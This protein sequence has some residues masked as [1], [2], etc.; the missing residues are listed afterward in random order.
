[1]WLSLIVFTGSALASPRAPSLEE[2]DAAING[3]NEGAHFPLP[4]VQEGDLQRLLSGE[5]VRILERSSTP[6]R[7]S[8]AVGLLLSDVPRDQVWV[9]CQD[10]HFAQNEQVSEAILAS[11]QPHRNTWFGLLDLPSPFA[12]RAW[13]VDVVNNYKLAQDSEN[14]A[15]EHYWELNPEGKTMATEA[16]ASGRIPDVDDK[17]LDQA[18]FTP[19]NH[20]AWLLVELPGGYS[21]FGYHSSTELAGNLP[22]NLVIQ[23]V[24]AQLGSM[25][26]EIV[27]RGRNQAPAHYDSDHQEDVHG[28]NGETIQRFQ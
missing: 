27:E 16:V 20:G 21:L 9:S 10:P 28:G 7:P 22:T 6:G 23:F 4:V 1:M 11:S 17:R 8:R 14:H 24:H 26:D 19:T 25:L 15:W 2:L 18:I 3:F 12:D 5:A 13:V